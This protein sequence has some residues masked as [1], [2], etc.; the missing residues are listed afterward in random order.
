MNQPYST[1]ATSSTILEGVFGDGAPIEGRGSLGEA[2]G[3]ARAVSPVVSLDGGLAGTLDGVA[4][5]E[6]AVSPEMRRAAMYLFESERDRRKALWKAVL[7]Y[8]KDSPEWSRTLTAPEADRWRERI[9]VYGDHVNRLGK[10]PFIDG[11]VAELAANL[12][13]GCARFSHLPSQQRMRAYKG[14]AK[15]RGKRR[16]ELDAVLQHHAEGVSWR[17]IAALTGVPMRTAR[18]WVVS[19]NGTPLETLILSAN[20]TPLADRKTTANGTPD[21]AIDRAISRPPDPEQVST[22]NNEVG[23]GPPPG[24]VAGGAVHA[25]ERERERSPHPPGGAV[26]GAEPPP[27]P[28]YPDGGATDG[29]PEPKVGE[30]V[31][32][33]VVELAE[34]HT[35][36]TGNDKAPELP[37]GFG[38]LARAIREGTERAKANPDRLRTPEELAQAALDRDAAVRE[39]DRL[40]VAEWYRAH[41]E[42]APGELE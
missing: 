15:K 37:A 32:S 40:R 28:V 23:A 16:K 27:T 3:I 42:H 22:T 29:G 1:T 35:A 26:G 20:G 5:L 30:Q 21:R 33:L 4:S 9:E 31:A 6:P 12:A 2:Q 13:L 24:R 19:A 39:R 17:K 41:P 18:R 38:G 14:A 10:A 36:P 8:G 34:R 11:T 7:A 25:A